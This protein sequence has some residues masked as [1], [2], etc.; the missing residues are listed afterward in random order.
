MRVQVL[1]SATLWKIFNLKLPSFSFLKQ[2]CC[3]ESSSSSHGAEAK[4]ASKDHPEGTNAEFRQKGNSLKNSDSKHASNFCQYL[5]HFQLELQAKGLERENHNFNIVFTLQKHCRMKQRHL[6]KTQAK[7]MSVTGST[8]WRCKL[9]QT[10]SKF[11]W[12]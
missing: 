5:L 9:S 3:W 1:K 11:S 2:P 7:Q 6:L 12:K 4:S 8:K 10:A